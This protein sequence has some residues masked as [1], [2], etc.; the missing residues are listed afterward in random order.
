[1]TNNR[2]LLDLAIKIQQIPAPTFS[3]QRRAE[4]VEQSFRAEGLAD[5][6]QDALGNVYSRLPG[7]GA[8]PLVVCAHLDTVVPE[9]APLTVRRMPG[10]IFGPGLG[11]NSLGVA[12]LFGLLWQLR[13]E[14]RQLPGDL[15]LIADVG[16]EGVGDLRGMRAVVDRFGANV[17]GYLIVE[18]LALGH[19]YHRAVGVQ[20]SRVTV[21]T[22]GGHSWADYGRPSAI[23]EMASLVTQLNRLKLPLEPR[24]TL[25][26]GVV[27]GGTSVNT[28][29]SDAA[30]ELDLRSEGPEE[31]A[32]L[33][34]DA[35]ARIGKARRAD[36]EIQ[37]EI[38]S[39][40]PP[41]AIPLSHPFVQLGLDCVRAQGLEAAPAAGSTDANIPLSLGLPAVVLGVTSGGG[42]H[43]R[44]EFIDTAPVEHGMAQ[45]LDFVRR[46]WELEF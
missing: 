4:F 29:A 1:M 38:T 21:R 11:D 32:A 13:Q 18:G 19:V 23:H 3:E 40:R 9:S 6:E 10:K 17:K 31:L 45:L 33:V 43:T 24:T 5:V 2:D 25:N 44:D 36:V 12:A 14:N 35:E 39:R 37:T 26:V 20:R 7:L 15:W 8:A 41:G 42:A 30:F 28:I 46:V 27:S 34:K 16:E 22:A